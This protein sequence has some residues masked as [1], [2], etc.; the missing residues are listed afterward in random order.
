MRRPA[1]RGTFLFFFLSAVL[2]LGSLLDVHGLV[3]LIDALDQVSPSCQPAGSDACTQ[4]VL[5]LAGIVDIFDVVP[6]GPY[7]LAE[8]SDIC[9]ID[10]RREFISAHPG[11]EFAGL[12]GIVDALGHLSDRFIAGIVAEIIIDVFE[13]VHVDRCDGH[14]VALIADLVELF[15]KLGLEASSVEQAGERILGIDFHDVRHAEELLI[16][17]ESV[18]YLSILYKDE[19]HRLIDEGHCFGTCFGL[20]TLNELLLSLSG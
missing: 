15:G 12:Q 17:I 19:L 4:F 10:D 2:F 6:D 9:K 3:S 11:N 18:D 14:V 20:E 13:S 7:E 16:D 1:V 5:I 8:S